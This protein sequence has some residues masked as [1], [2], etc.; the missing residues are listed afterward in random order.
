MDE[1]TKLL[2]KETH[3]D[4]KILVDWA[5]GSLEKGTIGVDEKVRVNTK[6]RRGF[7]KVLWIAAGPL[8]V[9]VAGAALALAFGG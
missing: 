9:G 8:I 4:V 6:F 7:V 5:K 2:I 3:E 1:P